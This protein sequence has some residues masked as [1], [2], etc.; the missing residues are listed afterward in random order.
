MPFAAACQ[1]IRALC[2]SG[3]HGSASAEPDADANNAT[4]RYRTPRQVMAFNNPA[5]CGSPNKTKWQPGAPWNH[6]KAK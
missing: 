5:P 1:A 4:D 3:D 6:Q 2:I